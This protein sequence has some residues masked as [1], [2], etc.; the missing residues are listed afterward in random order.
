MWFQSCPGPQPGAGAAA[1]PESGCKRYAA[2]T[3]TEGKGKEAREKS[4]PN[5]PK[6]IKYNFIFEALG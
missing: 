3:Q 2:H 6:H 5:K 1:K 4:Q